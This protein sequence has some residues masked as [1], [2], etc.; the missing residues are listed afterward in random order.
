[1]LV[2]VENPTQCQL[3]RSRS[4]GFGRVDFFI[5]W[6]IPTFQLGGGA[7]RT[8][9]NR[10]HLDPEQNAVSLR[11]R[12]SC[13]APMPM[14]SVRTAIA[15]KTG[16]LR[17]GVG[18]NEGLASIRCPPFQGLDA[19]GSSDGSSCKQRTKLPMIFQQLGVAAA[20][21]VSISGT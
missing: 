19:G 6:P 15:E 7:I 3:P 18:R 17:I 1:M 5:L 14:P 16:A 12:W 21:G 20:T 11:R 9:V 4:S 8:A 2:V 13:L 10:N